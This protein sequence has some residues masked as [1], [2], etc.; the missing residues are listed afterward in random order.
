MLT[1]SL[2]RADYN[3]EKKV[4]ACK[5]LQRASSQVSVYS[6]LVEAT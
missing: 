5:A 1:K 3:K 4:V 6:H 2:S